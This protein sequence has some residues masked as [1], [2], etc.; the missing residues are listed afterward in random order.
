MVAFSGGYG[1]PS[2]GHEVR[3]D[4]GAG[5][6]GLGMGGHHCAL[7]YD[8]LRQLA[9]R[10][11]SWWA[12]LDWPDCESTPSELNSAPPS[13]A[14]DDFTPALDPA[15]SAVVEA[16]AGS[17]KTWLLVARMVRLLLAGAA[18][19]TLLAIT[20]TRKAAEEMRARLIDGLRTLSEADEGVA[21]GYLLERGLS[22]AE[23]RAAL[24]R[25]RGLFEA[26]LASVPGPTVTT[27]HGWFLNL[28]GRAPM[29]R[30]PPANLI[31]DAVLLRAEAWQTWAETLVRPDK[32]PVTEALD[33][34]LEAA[35]L[36]SV[37]TWLFSVLANR[38]EGWAWAGH[39]GTVWARSAAALRALSGIDPELDVLATLWQRPGFQADLAEFR[40]LLADNAVASKT[41]ASRLAAL[42]AGLAEADP[43]R[44]FAHLA[45]AFLTQA[46]PPIVRKPAATL[47]KRL[48][49][50]RAARFLALHGQLAD[51]LCDATRQR[52]EQQAQR[53][54]VWALRAGA[55]LIAHYQALKRSRDGLDFTDA[56]WL[57]A[58]LLA[59]P[60]DSAAVLAKLDARWQ[61]VLLDEFQD[62][63]PVQWRILRA[64]LSAYG[65]DGERPTLFMVGDPKQSIYRFRRAEPRLFAQAG[66]WLAANF[67]AARLH[68]NQ[69]RR[70]APRVVAWLNGVFAGLGPAYPDFHP[71]TAWNAGL[72]GWCELIVVPAARAEPVPD[73]P[74]LP[75]RDPL[76]EP[77]PETPHKRRDEA[78]AVATRIQSIVGR[79]WLD[80]DGGRPARYEDILVL[81]ASRTGLEAFEAA[82]RAA[83]IPF[84][85]SRRGGLL[86]TLEAGDLEAV[87][88][89]LAMPGD[90]LSLARTL[91][92]PLFG[93][94][95]ADLLH[96][97]EVGDGTWLAR[98]AAWAA[99]P[100]APDRVVRAARLLAGWRAL[101]GR[102]PPHDLLDRVVHE[103]DAEARYA[104]AVPDRL[105]ASTLANL[106][107]VLA[108]S[109]ELGGGRYPSLPRF[110]D[111]LAALRDEAGDDAPDEP[112]AAVGDVV[113][114]MTI[115]AAKGLEAPVVF[116]VKVDEA[117]RGQA[118]YGVLVDWPPEA[119]RPVHLSAY[120]PAELRGA[121]RAALFEQERTLAAREHLNL[122]Y[123]A[124][125]RARQALFASGLDSEDDAGW[126]PS[127]QAGWAAASLDGLPVMAWHDPAPAPEAASGASPGQPPALGPVG[128]R[129]V[130]TPEIDFG[131]W[132]HRALE[133]ATEGA[134]PADI[135]RELGLDPEAWAAVWR[136]AEIFLDQPETRR[137]FA[138]GRGR[139]EVAYVGPDGQLRRIDRLV[140]FEAEV[141]VIDYKT[142]GLAEPDL[143]R[144]AEP[145]REQL[146]EYRAAMRA[147]FPDKPVRSALLFGDGR[148]L[149]VE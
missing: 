3:R 112:P 4:G 71:H 26:V 92:C 12:L 107:G 91:K 148:W 17:G 93:F 98:L 144:R 54:N 130:S 66:D 14:P 41:D 50:G 139:N 36:A 94:G 7:Q 77:A 16:C 1:D 101:A 126:L 65:A 131:I 105:R 84:L 132:V 23:A 63:N 85:G 135:E 6:G 74:D 64:W 118:P 49:A 28:L 78:A 116:L 133:R 24:P 134:P 25:A 141:W 20:F 108:L 119:E 35:P 113:R 82:F 88:R 136:M 13:P 44:R 69:T 59:D 143:A 56:E 95:D 5:L 37:Q 30:R 100:A 104:A 34:L 57:A 47:D 103:A 147:L 76:G 121:A 61:H 83:G 22:E 114:M 87:L 52:A 73:D 96:L 53:L 80:V 127:L 109:L 128:R 29:Q 21:L 67:S 99:D 39:D 2:G 90:D 60:E 9:C 18:P 106:R 75:W 140:E 51:A 124:M 115:H 32:A 110:L 58:E 129:R 138:E 117:R 102:L 123:V 33:G 68:Q 62:A 89:V 122:L 15:H 97:A 38:A 55:D 86:H 11:R 8:A 19:S 70:C 81:S 31:E 45:Q 111:E 43:E 40:D 137:F 72:P 125:T 149:E 10:D 145:Y 27:F 42:D 79:L 120:G 146:A 48:G 142:G 46:G